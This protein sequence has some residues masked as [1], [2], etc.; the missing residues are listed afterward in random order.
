MVS[1]SFYQF[2]FIVKLFCALSRDPYN[3]PPI[4][5]IS[6]HSVDLYE[7]AWV[8]AIGDDAIFWADQFIWIASYKR[9]S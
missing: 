8:A 7:V 9:F 5:D 4:G 1:D 3:S 2:I 6:C